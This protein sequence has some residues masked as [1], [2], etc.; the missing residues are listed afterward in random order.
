MKRTTVGIKKMAL[1]PSC[2]L[3]CSVTL[4]TGF[5]LI[6]LGALCISNEYFL[7]QNMS[8][9]GV[10]IQLLMTFI[11]C[12]LAG[13]VTAGNQIICC[14]A[15][16]ATALLTMMSTSILFFDGVSS[17]VFTGMIAAIIGLAASTII[18]LRKGNCSPR[19]A[20]RKRSR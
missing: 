13:R 11:G 9:I 10:I 19:R 20:K 18:I 15:T 16:A 14:T 3:G 2:A 17:S 4:C 8:I 12:M 5:M 1:L 6:A 7:P